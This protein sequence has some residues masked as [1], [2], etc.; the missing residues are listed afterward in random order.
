MITIFDY[1]MHTIK[2]SKL[3]SS[4]VIIVSRNSLYLDKIIE[5]DY[6]KYKHYLFQRLQK[7]IVIVNHN[8]SYYKVLLSFCF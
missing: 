7:I 2:F 8:Y 1:F 4:I 5:H 3:I 6:K